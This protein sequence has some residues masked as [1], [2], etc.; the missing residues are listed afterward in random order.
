MMY[1]KCEIVRWLADDPQ[2]GVVEACL[3]D[4]EG[5]HWSFADKVAIFD[6]TGTV[7][8]ASSYPQPGLIRCE[9]L[10]ASCEAGPMEMIV[11]TLRPDGVST[12]AGHSTFRV[13]LAQL[14]WSREREGSA[15]PDDR[16]APED[17]IGARLLKV[18]AAWHVVDSVRSQVLTEVWLVFDSVGLIRAEVASDWQLRIDRQRIHGPYD[19][20]DLGR[21]EIDTPGDA[22]PLSEHVGSRVVSVEAEH[23]STFGQLMGLKMR[24]DSGT[25][26]LRSW[27][28]D[29]RVE[30]LRS[31]D[32]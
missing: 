26:R 20:Q 17:L 16:V 32:R 31:D 4:A 11:T 9:A 5:R 3:I 2:P 21:I 6:M 8:P 1:L 22:L 23:E 27:G 28:G 30:A 15:E 12:E 7:G 19:M 25:I 18:I 10:D 29:L 14:S 13:E 24:F